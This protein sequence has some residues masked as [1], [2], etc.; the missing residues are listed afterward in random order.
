[1]LHEGHDADVVRGYILH[2]CKA[3]MLSWMQQL[4]LSAHL[5]GLHGHHKVDSITLYCRD[6]VWI[7]LNGQ[8]AFQGALLSGWHPATKL[9]VLRTEAQ[10]PILPLR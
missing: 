3:T 2:S 1:M 7:P 9:R 4:L 6:E 5:R 8:Q 10:S